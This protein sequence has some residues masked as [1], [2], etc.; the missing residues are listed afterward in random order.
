MQNLHHP[1]ASLAKKRRGRAED[2][3]KKIFSVSSLYFS[4]FSVVNAFEELLI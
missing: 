1:L 4:V 2:T 3:K